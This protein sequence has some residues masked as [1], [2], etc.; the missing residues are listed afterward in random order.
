MT[1]TNITKEFI[2]VLADHVIKRELTNITSMLNDIIKPMIAAHE[3]IVKYSDDVN[4]IFKC[5]IVQHKDIDYNNVYEYLYVDDIKYINKHKNTDKG[6]EKFKEMLLNI[7]TEIDLS[8]ASFNLTNLV[9]HYSDSNEQDY[10][11]LT[12]INTFIDDVERSCTFTGSFTNED[13]KKC[14]ECLQPTLHAYKV[15]HKLAKRTRNQ[16]A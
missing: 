9:L 16:K 2:N 5:E 4:Y 10:N 3:T 6:V 15:F 12:E 11:A 1:T 8:S 7:I 13:L 14:I